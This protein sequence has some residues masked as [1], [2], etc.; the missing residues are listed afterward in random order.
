MKQEALRKSIVFQENLG[1]LFPQKYSEF[2]QLSQAKMSEAG[3]E[4]IRVTND[5]RGLFANIWNDVGIK[6]NEIGDDFVQMIQDSSRLFHDK[7]NAFQEA[8]VINV[9]K[10]QDHLASQLTDVGL[11]R[12]EIGDGF[13]PIIQDSSRLFHDKTNAFQEASVI[14]V[15]KAQDHLAKIAS[16]SRE[17]SASAT[18]ESAFLKSI[19]IDIVD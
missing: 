1:I 3:D 12:K 9:D 2:Q 13:G 10:V 5:I 14:N 17:D 11:K 6:R 15:N 19:L 18:T 16:I 4:A 8:I 7:T